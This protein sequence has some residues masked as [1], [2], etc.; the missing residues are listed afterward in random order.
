MIPANKVAEISEK[1]KEP[2]LDLQSKLDKIQELIIA[3]ASKG[4]HSLSVPLEFFAEGELE[5]ITKILRLSQYDVDYEFDLKIPM[6]K[7]EDIVVE[8]DIPVVNIGWKK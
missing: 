1:N 7:S 6:E 3:A 5:H 2:E 4:E 8:R